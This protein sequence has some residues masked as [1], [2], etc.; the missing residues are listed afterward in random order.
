M[1]SEEPPA[2][3]P[4]PNGFDRYVLLSKIHICPE[5][6][7]TLG[8][9]AS[10]CDEIEPG[11]RENGQLEP[12]GITPCPHGWA[13]V[14]KYHLYTVLTHIHAET[15]SF[16]VWGRV[17]AYFSKE[18][19]LLDQWIENHHRKIDPDILKEKFLLPLLNSGN[20]QV[21]A[22]KKL[23]I[24]KSY[25]TM[26][27]HPE[28]YADRPHAGNG[29]HPVNFEQNGTSVAPSPSDGQPVPS[30]LP[31]PNG[32]MTPAPSLP[33]EAPSAFSEI[34]SGGRESGLA[35]E[36]PATEVSK[37]ESAVNPAHGSNGGDGAEATIVQSR[38]LP[39]ASSKVTS[40]VSEP[41]LSSPPAPPS[42]LPALQRA[43]AL[44]Q[45]ALKASEWEETDDATARAAAQALASA[46]ASIYDFRA[47]L[48]D[49]QRTK[50]GPLPR[51]QVFTLQVMDEVRIR[52][53]E[54]GHRAWVTAHLP[55]GKANLR[56]LRGKDKTEEIH[57]E[58]D[59]ILVPKGAKA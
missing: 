22:A 16:V 32:S 4:G 9:D 5:W 56:V 11:V 47:Y 52:T 54:N 6:P 7:P 28:E 51:P 31:P 23:G 35:Q 21:R 18:E 38:S 34:P 29:V 10:W 30:V 44:L 20:N 41:P 45:T 13:V 26:L 14:F 40:T 42:P 2:S 25:V 39:I 57:L 15:P 46:E 37:R 55:G 53:E 49:G 24:S 43:V 3:G 48:E 36:A 12:I 19:H 1:R 33:G 50:D 27:L 59:L 17:R 58:R 8:I